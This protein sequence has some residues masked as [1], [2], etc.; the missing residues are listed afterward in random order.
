MMM[1][2]VNYGRD[3]L[4]FLNLVDKAI[5][6]TTD[7]EAAYIHELRWQMKEEEWEQ[8]RG[9]PTTMPTAKETYIPCL[10]LWRNT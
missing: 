10:G 6:R 8:A 4:L 3:E 1:E 7:S 5:S 2:N 9:E